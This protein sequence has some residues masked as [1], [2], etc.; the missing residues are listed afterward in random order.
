LSTSAPKKG[1]KSKKKDHKPKKSGNT[2]NT[3][4][5]MQETL[6]EEIEEPIPTENK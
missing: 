3:N 6:L 2:L 5:F 1:K 4:M